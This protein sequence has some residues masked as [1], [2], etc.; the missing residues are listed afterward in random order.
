MFLH[1]RQ[2]QSMLQSVLNYGK[3][4]EKIYNTKFV[5]NKW[6]LFASNTDTDH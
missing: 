2:P 3:L 5:S 4:W 1:K 6:M